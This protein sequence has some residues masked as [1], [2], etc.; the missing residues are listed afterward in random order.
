MTSQ[1]TRGSCKAY[2]KFEQRRNKILRKF[3]K[4]MASQSSERFE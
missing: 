4:A 2:R 1:I 3:E